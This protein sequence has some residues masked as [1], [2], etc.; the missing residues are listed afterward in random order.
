MKPYQSTKHGKPLR[1]NRWRL[2]GAGFHWFGRDDHG[3][4]VWEGN[5]RNLRWGYVLLG[6]IGCTAFTIGAALFVLGRMLPPFAILGPVGL[7]HTGL[8]WWMKR[9]HDKLTELSTV[10]EVAESLGVEPAQLERWAEGEARPRAIINQK[11]YYHPADLDD[12]ARLLRASEA[13]ADDLLLRPARSANVSEE[14]L[15]RPAD[16]FGETRDYATQ[17]TEELNVIQQLDRTE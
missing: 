12:A 3:V 1:K 9:L 15:V 6:A 2:S 14:T 5:P 13:P 4:S 10:E 16:R 7:I 11:P 8:A 17:S